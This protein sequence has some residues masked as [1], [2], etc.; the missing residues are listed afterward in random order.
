MI[1]PP[2]VLLARDIQIDAAAPRGG[3]DLAA[4]KLFQVGTRAHP[5]PSLVSNDTFDEAWVRPTRVALPPLDPGATTAASLAAF[6]ASPGHERG[7]FR[8]PRV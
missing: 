1:A 7:V 6:P 2:P 4:S 5:Q 3:C 8:P